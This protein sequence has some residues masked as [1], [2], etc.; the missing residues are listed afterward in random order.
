MMYAAQKAVAM[1]HPVPQQEP[2]RYQQLPSDA[3]GAQ[4]MQTMMNYPMMYHPQ[5]PP[6][7]Q[8]VDMADYLLMH[9]TMPIYDVGLRSLQQQQQQQNQ[10]MMHMNA[11][12]TAPKL[13]QGG[14]EEKCRMNYQN[15]HDPRASPF[16]WLHWDE[17]DGKTSTDSLTQGSREPGSNASFAKSSTPAGVPG[18]NPAQRLTC[19]WNA[20]TRCAR[21]GA[22]SGAC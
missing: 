11:G 20:S 18:S 3:I 6:V 1:R 14:A 21:S 19:L 16:E 2:Q 22:D 7:Q 15:P 9:S 4:Q 17:I 10:Q 12:T 8:Q 5:Q 13:Q